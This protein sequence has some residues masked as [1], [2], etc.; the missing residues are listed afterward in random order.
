MHISYLS[1]IGLQKGI[2]D[3]QKGAERTIIVREGIT[4]QEPD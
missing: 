2:Q 1:I 4:A 3:E